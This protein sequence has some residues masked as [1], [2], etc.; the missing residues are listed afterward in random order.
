MLR[1][2]LGVVVALV[3]AA[4]AAGC[5]GGS[6]RHESV[7]SQAKSLHPRPLR[8]SSHR[9]ETVAGRVLGLPAVRSRVVP[10]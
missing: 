3:L 7:T 10:G 1:P 4:L 9:H 5:S 8:G 6:H 2:L